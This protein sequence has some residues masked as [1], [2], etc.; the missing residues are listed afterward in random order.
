MP[1]VEEYTELLWVPNIIGDRIYT[2]PE[3]GTNFSACLKNLAG[4]NSH[5]K[6]QLLTV[7]IYGY[8]IFSRILGYIDVAIL[9]LFNQLE[10]GINPV[11]AI[12]A[13]TF[14]SLNA[15]RELEGGR[16]RGCAPLLMVWIKSHFWKTPRTILPEVETIFSWRLR[17]QVSRNQVVIFSG[18]SPLVRCLRLTES[19]E[20]R[21]VA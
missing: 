18:F 14:I 13:E 7:A 9:D 12:L 17:I 5:K 19:E 2:K 21:F 16:F 4:R 6:A 15:C 8:M 10:H 11:P 20:V 3:K 1:T